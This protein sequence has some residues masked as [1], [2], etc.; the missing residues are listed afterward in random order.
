M[1]RAVRGLRRLRPSDRR[2]FVVCWALLGVSRLLILLLPF[3]LLRRMLGANNARDEAL[4]FPACGL[5]SARRIGEMTR[6]AARHTPWRSECYPQAL[7]ARIQ[8]VIAGIPNTLSFGLR[9]SADGALLAHAWVTVGELSV[10]G[11][12]PQPYTVVGS[13]SWQPTPSSSR[14]F[15]GNVRL[16]RPHAAKRDRAA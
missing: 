10:V 5:A 6:L 12:D 13:F 15:H 4:P 16:L 9:R 3:S 14:K 7:A 1:A 2:R 11:G 8:L